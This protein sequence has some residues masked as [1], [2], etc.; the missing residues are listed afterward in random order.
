MISVIITSYKEPKTIVKAIACIGNQSPDEIIVVAPDKETLDAAKSMIRK[1]KQLR[2]IKDDGEGKPAAL[3]LAVKEARGDILVLTDGDVVVEKDSIK[4]LVE[5]LEDDKYGAV[6]GNP[7]S[8][9]SRNNKFGFWAY[10]LTEIANKRRE[11]AALSGKRFFCSGYLFA[12]RKNLFPII[13]ENLLSEDGFI[14]HKVYEKG[15]KIAYAKESKVYVKYP[16]N[17]SDWIKQKKRSAG[18]YNQIKKML[19]VEIRSFRSESSGAFDFLNYISS[20]KEIYW[21]VSLFVARVY[22]WLLIYKDIN[23]KNKDQKELWQRIEST[24]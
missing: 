2:I 16:N 19:G 18:G 8:L 23:I 7:I 1:F 21:L 13:P 3:N 9:N 20:M 10:M 5:K 11:K 12:I 6:S 22:L 4:K 17:F 14:S 24:K 15:Y